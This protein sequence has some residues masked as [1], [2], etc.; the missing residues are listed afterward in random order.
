[1]LGWWGD[2]RH[3]YGMHVAW[4][5]ISS[6]CCTSDL[7]FFLNSINFSSPCPPPPPSTPSVNA[8]DLL[9]TDDLLDRPNLRG[10]AVGGRHCATSQKVASSIP[11]GVIEIFH[12][13]N[14]SR[15]VALGSIQSLTETSTRGISSGVKAAGA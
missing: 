6:P 15:T 3:V 4:Q 14:S 2:A 9:L 13:L 7:L 10:G 1:V 11:E 12:W 8:S 5:S